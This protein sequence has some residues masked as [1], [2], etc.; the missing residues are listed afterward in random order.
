MHFWI[1]KTLV[2]SNI[3]KKKRRIRQYRLC[4]PGFGGCGG[5]KELNRSGTK[6]AVAGPLP[7]VQAV[8][9]YS[10]VSECSAKVAM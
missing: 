1:S 3:S 7:K 10:P 8:P 5:P 2:E 4:M 9:R 6:C